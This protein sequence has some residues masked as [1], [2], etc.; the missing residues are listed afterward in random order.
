MGRPII[1]YGQGRRTVRFVAPLLALLLVIAAAWQGALPSEGPLPEAVK[2][3][4][5]RTFTK[6]VYW[7]ETSFDGEDSP[8]IIG[9]LGEDPFEELLDEAVRGRTAHGRDLRVRRLP[10]IDGE[11]PPVEQL[12]DCHLLF[13]SA[14]ERDRLPLIFERLEGSNVMTVSDLEDFADIGGVAE[15]VLIG[16]HIRFRFNRQA[17][18]VASLRPSARLLSSAIVVEPSR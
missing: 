2:A 13:V 3:A 14:S 4:Y 17:A 6:L 5:L 11:I 18:D 8:V 16:P 9:V 7:P 1:E 12:S 15:F 10:V